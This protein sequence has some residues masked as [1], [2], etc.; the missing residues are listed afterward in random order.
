MDGA[1]VE[2]HEE[3]GDENIIIFGLSSDEVSKMRREHSY[4]PWDIYNSDP[5]VK[6]VMDSLIDGTFSPEQ[7]EIFR[8][9]LKITEKN[10][11]VFTTR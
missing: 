10:S 2:I 1:N 5:R 4:N 8:D 7:P 6:R 9:F 3:V 11:G